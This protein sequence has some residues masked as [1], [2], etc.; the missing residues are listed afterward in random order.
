M[1]QRE[2][3]F[4]ALKDD[5]SNCSFVYGQLVYDTIGRPRITEVDF[6]GQGL[7]FHTC[8]KNTEGQFAG[9]KDCKGNDVFDG[10]ILKSKIADEVEPGGWLTIF[11]K[12]GFENGAFG[13]YGETTFDHYPFCNEDM[14]AF[15]VAGDIHNT[16][17]LLTPPIINT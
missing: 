12:V 3:R 17:E 2:I 6:S 15:E 5:V 7:T 11:N 1:T 8:I 9:V 13:Y 10:D 16:P 14:N 4:R